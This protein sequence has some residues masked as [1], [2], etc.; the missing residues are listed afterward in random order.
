MSRIEPANFGP[1]LVALMKQALERAARD[2]GPSPATKAKM[3]ERIVLTVAGGSTGYG[4][5]VAAAI[6]EGRT[7]AA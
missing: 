3:A 2:V 1:E 4:T 6:D 7:P 5:L